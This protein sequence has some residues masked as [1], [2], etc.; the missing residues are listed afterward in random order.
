MQKNVRVKLV[1]EPLTPYE[2]NSFCSANDAVELLRRV[3]SP[4]V[5]SMCDLVPPFVQFESIMEYLTKLGDK[6]YHFPYYRRAAGNGQPYYA[7]G[8]GEHT[9]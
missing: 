7:G 6:M 8:K 2:S 1:V 4:Y 5:V 9:A 3:D